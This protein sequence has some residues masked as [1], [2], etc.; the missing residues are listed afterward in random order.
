MNMA[1]LVEWSARRY[2]DR[3]AFIFGDQSLTYGEV[4]RRANRLAHGLL[5]LGIAKGD[6]IAIIVSNRPE[7]AE[8]EFAVAKVG[9]LRVPMLITSTVPELV[10][11]LTA[12]ECTA[13]I[14]SPEAA[15]GVRAAVDQLDRDLVIV[16]MDS[17]GPGETGYE[18]LLGASPETPVAVDIAG[19]DL[20]ALRFTGGT[21]GGPKGVLMSHRNMVTTTLNLTLNWPIDETDVALHIH[22]M[23]HAAGMMMYSYWTVGAVNVIHPAFGFD[24]HEFVAAVERHRVTSVFI[25]PTVLNVLLD[26]DALDGADTSSLRSI[27]YGGAPIPLTRLQQGLDRIGPV[28]IQ[29]YGSSEAPMALT[30]LHRDEHLLVDGKAPAR[31]RSAGREILNVEVRVVDPEMQT[32]PPG[33]VGE[34]AARGDNTMVGY[35]K[36]PELTAQRVVDGWVRTGDMGYLDEEGYLYIVDRKEDMIITGGFNV[37]PAEIEDVIYQHPAVNSAVVFGVDD[38]KWGEAVTAAVVPRSGA[39]VEEAEMIAFLA[40]RLTKYKVPKRVLIRDSPIPQSAVGKPLRRQVRTEY[41]D[42]LERA[43]R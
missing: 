33:E 23:S 21:T 30:T 39:A 32:L 34:V 3:T 8:A 29:V 38:P 27:V 7:Y 6:R 11:W 10:R 19:D 41:L 12:S 31:L 28:F 22:P 25:I 4:D 13:A 5:E 35:W 16:M 36:N 43:G 17:A 18:E 42:A 40:E 14:V 1:H 9:A 2:R 37:W 24:P 15:D 26:S 20:Y